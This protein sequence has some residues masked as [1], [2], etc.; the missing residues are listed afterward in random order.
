MKPTEFYI[1]GTFEKY[2]NLS[3]VKKSV[4]LDY[5]NKNRKQVD[6]KYI[7]GYNKPCETVVSMTLINVD[8]A[9]RYRFGKTKKLF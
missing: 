8:N 1:E 6:G 3:A 5:N 2:P 4:Y 9:G 7:I